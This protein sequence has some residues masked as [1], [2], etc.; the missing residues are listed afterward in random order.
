MVQQQHRLVRSWRSCYRRLWFWS[1]SGCWCWCG[2][3]VD[4]P[5]RLRAEWMA[6]LLSRIFTYILNWLINWYRIVLEA[7]E[8]E[9]ANNLGIISHSIPYHALPRI[10]MWCEILWRDCYFSGHH[11]QWGVKFQIISVKLSIC[12][13][14]TYTSTN[15]FLNGPICAP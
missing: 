14:S 7:A 1:E 11:E 3:R 4:R 5:N 2:D 10:R 13:Y 15:A 12:R 8:R 6:S 9:N